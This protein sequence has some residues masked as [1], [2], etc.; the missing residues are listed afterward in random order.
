[1]PAWSPDGSAIAFLRGQANLTYDLYSINPNGGGERKLASNVAP[2]RYSVSP[3]NYWQ[4][5]AFAWSPD[6]SQIAYVSK[7]V[8]R[9]MFG[10]CVPVMARMS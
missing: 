5:K 8:A 4:A 7:K 3:Y 1:M 10:P 2:G 9:Q 6:A